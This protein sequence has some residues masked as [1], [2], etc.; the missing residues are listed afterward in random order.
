MRKGLSTLSP[1]E[2]L[3]EMC[4]ELRKH[5]RFKLVEGAL[6]TLSV[7]GELFI[8]IGDILDISEG[9]LAFGYEGNG[10]WPREGFKVDLIGYPESDSFDEDSN[11]NL[12]TVFVE[13]IPERERES[14]T[15]LPWRRTRGKNLR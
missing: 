1:K 9:G 15:R 13:T 10:T 3:P 2:D 14:S 12:H 7:P 5:R 11:Q 4:T 6:A 8:R